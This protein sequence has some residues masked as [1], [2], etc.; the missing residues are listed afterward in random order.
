ML[1]GEKLFFIDFVWLNEVKILFFIVNLLV[2]ASANHKGNIKKKF[3][4]KAE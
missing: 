3:V 4:S 1:F 2:F